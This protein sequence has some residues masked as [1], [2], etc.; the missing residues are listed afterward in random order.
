MSKRNA[1]N[2]KEKIIE[3]VKSFLLILY[4]NLVCLFLKVS[5]LQGRELGKKTSIKERKKFPKKLKGSFYFLK[6]SLPSIGSW[7]IWVASYKD[8]I[9]NSKSNEMYN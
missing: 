7:K 8:V 1:L 3:L 6:F 5:L 4:I 9:E 2:G